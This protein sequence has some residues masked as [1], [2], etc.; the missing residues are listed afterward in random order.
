MF[1]IFNYIISFISSRPHFNRNPS[2]QMVS[3][4]S[5]TRQTTSIHIGRHWRVWIT[6]VIQ[7]ELYRKTN[8][9]I[10]TATIREVIRERYCI[11]SDD[12]VYFLDGSMNADDARVMGIADATAQWIFISGYPSQFIDCFMNGIPSNW[13]QHILSHKIWKKKRRKRWSDDDE[14]KE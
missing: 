8:G 1:I 3:H 2:R 13:T 7:R 14:S 9:G 11:C 6:H 10:V 5:R 12:S 4:R